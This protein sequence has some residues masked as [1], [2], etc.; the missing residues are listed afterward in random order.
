MVLVSRNIR[1]E[2]VKNNLE[3]SNKMQ[4]KGSFTDTIM[5]IEKPFLLYLIWK[6]DKI[7]KDSLYS[8][9][10]TLYYMQE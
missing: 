8:I 7:V 9:H 3:N 5:L 4:A 6:M 10:Y 2:N 1:K